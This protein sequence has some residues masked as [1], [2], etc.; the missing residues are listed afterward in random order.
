MGILDIVL[1]TLIAAGVGAAVRKCVS[2]RKNG[3]SC[4]GNCSSCQGCKR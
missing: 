2:D 4:C 1:L 3:K